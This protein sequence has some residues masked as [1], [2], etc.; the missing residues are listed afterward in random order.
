M[1][2]KNKKIK[3]IMPHDYYSIVDNKGGIN[4]NF[5]INGYEYKLV[6]NLKFYRNNLSDL[7]TL[8]SYLIYEEFGLNLLFESYVTDAINSI[9]I[10]SYTDYLLDELYWE[11]FAT[12]K[13]K[14]TDMPPTMSIINV[15]VSE[16]CN[17]LLIDSIIGGGMD[18]LSVSSKHL[19]LDEDVSFLPHKILTDYM[20]KSYILPYS[21]TEY[22][23]NLHK[24]Y[25][26]EF[27]C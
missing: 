17:N 2:A 16:D 25:E 6:H 12:M 11:E 18:N 22:G 10:E 5:V 21:V 3:L 20:N 13:Y 26:G 9:D 1:I 27:G 7:I 24:D 14:I 23:Y 8:E 15:L 19:L 4:N